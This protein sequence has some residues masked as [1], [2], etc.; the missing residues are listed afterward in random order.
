MNINESEARHILWLC[1]VAESETDEEET[2]LKGKIFQAFPRI[3]ADEDEHEFN[4]WLWSTRTEEDSDVRDAR[5][6]MGF[7]IPFNEWYNQEE[8]D[9]PKSV[10][11]L[12]SEHRE[13]AMFQFEETKKQVYERLL[14]E[15]ASGDIDLHNEWEVHKRLEKIGKIT[16]KE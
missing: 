12:Y 1:G 7:H 15:D 14:K 3:K 9:K 8:S 2:Y 10:R 4:H 6:L 16:L 11:T 13:V 5:F